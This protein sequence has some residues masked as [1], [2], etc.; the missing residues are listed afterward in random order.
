MKIPSTYSLSS[1]K[2]ILRKGKNLLL[3][4]VVSSSKF[5]SEIQEIYPVSFCGSASDKTVYTLILPTIE[6]LLI[7]KGGSYIR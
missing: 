3:G 6:I 4:S 1:A 7:N 2:K 5:Y